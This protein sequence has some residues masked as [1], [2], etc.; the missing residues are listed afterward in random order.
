VLHARYEKA[1]T[2][3]E[4]AL[5]GAGESREERARSQVALARVAR[6]LGDLPLARERLAAAREMAAAGLAPAEL[7]RLDLESAWLALAEG[8]ESEA[9][10]A[11]ELAGALAARVLGDADPTVAW[12]EAGRGEALRRLGDGAAADEALRDAL[13]RF[14]GEA[15]ADAMTPEEPLGLLAAL[16]SLGALRR[17]EGKLED[18]R[19]DLRSALAIGAREVGTEHPRYA[20][21]LAELALVELGRGDLEAARR[22]AARADQ[23]ARSRLPE[24]HATRLAAA[25]ALARCGAP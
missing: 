5:A 20:D 16:T 11:F 13:M 2:L 18:A 12:A 15:N 3:L 10:R 14:G 7:V 8:R 21:A 23:I 25:D 6:E 9:A 4:R 1:E 17:G 19:T 22:A 24:G